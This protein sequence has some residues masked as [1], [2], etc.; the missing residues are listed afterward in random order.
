MIDPTVPIP[1]GPMPQ[2]PVGSRREIELTIDGR[3]FAELN[4]ITTPQRADPASFL[5][6]KRTQPLIGFSIVSPPGISWPQYARESGQQIYDPQFK[7]PRLC[8]RCSFAAS[9]PNRHY[10]ISAQSLADRTT[11]TIHT[12]P[13]QEQ[14][15]ATY[16]ALCFFRCS[17]HRRFRAAASDRVPTV[18]SLRHRIRRAKLGVTPKSL[19]G[20]T[21]IPH[22]GNGLP[23]SW[24]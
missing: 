8:Q 13:G 11:H 1:R 6:E 18:R 21:P 4:T 10:S 3:K 24:Q 9:T 7:F 5:Q 23:A 12:H 2:A 19:V 16:A 20:L 15:G 14:P 22:S 17:A